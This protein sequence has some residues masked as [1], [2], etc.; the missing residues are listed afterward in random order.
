MMPFITAF[1]DY[2]FPLGQFHPNQCL[3]LKAADELF[4]SNRTVGAKKPKGSKILDEIL[5]FFLFVMFYY[6]IPFPSAA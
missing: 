2:F 6:S 5:K 3:S 4:F 1:Q